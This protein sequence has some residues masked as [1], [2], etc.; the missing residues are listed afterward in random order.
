MK[1]YMRDYRKLQR[2]AIQEAR[3][4]LGF[5]TKLRK[6]QKKTPKTRRAKR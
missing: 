2:Q 1:D 4:V 5:N 3:R 6:P